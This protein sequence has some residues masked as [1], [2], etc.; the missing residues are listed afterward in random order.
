MSLALRY[1]PLQDAVSNSGCLTLCNVLCKE[2]SEALM[3]QTY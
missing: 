2:N 1:C 3:F